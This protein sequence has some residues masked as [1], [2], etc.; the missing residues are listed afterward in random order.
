VHVPVYSPPRTPDATPAWGIPAIAQYPF[1]GSA[2]MVWDSG[3]PLPPI[4]N[5]PP[6][7]GFDPH[8]DPRN[9]PDVRQQKSD[10]LKA[11]GVVTDVCGPQACLADHS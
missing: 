7:A 11:N 1:A 5:T 8:Q 4:T 6:R 10:F 2:L 9:D 3:A